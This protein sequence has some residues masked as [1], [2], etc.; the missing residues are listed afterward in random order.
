MQNRFFILDAM[1]LIYRAYFAMIRSQRITSNGVNTS[2][3]FGFINFLYDILQKEKPTHIAVCIDSMTPTF[4]HEE[5]EEYKANREKMPEEIASNLPYIREIISAFNIQL[6]ERPGFE[7]DDLIGTLATK[8]S[9]LDDFEIFIVTPDKDLSQVVNDKVK[10]FKPAHGKTPQEILDVAA[11][12]EKYN[13]SDPK[14]VIDY[15]GLVGDS[16]DNIPGV[17][18]VGPVA[19]K[20]LIGEF[21]TIENIIANVDKIKNNSLKNKIMA[22]VDNAI[23]S[24]HLATIITDV[25]CEKDIS[26]FAVQQPD[27]EAVINICE[28]LEFRL[29]EKRF[30]TDLSL[31]GNFPLHKQDPTAQV[32]DTQANS[33]NTQPASLYE[34]D[35]MLGGLFAPEEMKSLELP[36]HNNINNT[37]H[38]YRLVTSDEDIDKLI[39]LLGE[40]KTF[41]FD[42]ET[43]SLNANDCDLVGMSF[44]IE[45]H[46]AFFVLCPDNYDDTLRILKKFQPLFT[47]KDNLIIGQNI[48]FDM[49]VL[50]L[51]GIT[52]ESKIFDTMIAH[53]LINP[54]T[55]HN[56]NFLSELY[57]DYSPV[58]IETLIG[59]KG[60]N[61]GNMRNVETEPLKEY[62]A[63]DA[64]VTLQLYYKLEKEI[65]DSGYDKLFEN[66]EMPLVKVLAAMEHEGVKIDTDFLSKYRIAI[67][68]DIRNLEKQIYEYAGQQFNIG[69]PKQL[70]EILFDKL[71]LADK[72]KKTKKGQYSTNEEVL[73]KLQYSH[74]IIQ[75][76]I[77]YRS[78]TKL[79]SGYVEPLPQ[80]INHRTGMVHTT[81]N[82]AI[83]ATGRL[84]SNNPNLQN[85]PVRTE[86]GK[87]IRK[88][89]IPRDNEH[90]I[91]SA[92]YSQIELRLIAHIADDKNMQQ[93]FI[94]GQDVHKATA[95]QIFDVDIAD[96]DSEM[97]R[98]AKTINFGIIY[99]M[100]TFG[101]AER[102]HVP[103]TKASYI[104]SQYFE[105]YPAIK[106]Y[107]TDI[108]AF[109]KENG[110]V[111]TIMG[112]RR[113]IA[114]I[115]SA[116]ANVR[117]YA[118]RNAINAP[119][120]GASADMIKVAMVRINN[121][122]K[123]MG[124]QSKMIIQVHDELV[125]DAL[126]TEKDTLIDIV[127]HEM[128]NAV[129][130]AIPIEV[131]VGI[132]DNWLEAH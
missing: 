32:S 56:M 94:E 70:G 54:E 66:V 51:Y 110:Y 106:Q 73:Q 2:A 119:I 101:L 62:A 20:K 27:A 12:C 109:A 50:A 22:N 29:F 121:R 40:T 64:D 52:I 113:Y 100:S 123:E 59:K 31:S 26:S 91:I 9:Q 74:P 34:N 65:H 88:A 105:K 128:E 35:Y 86:R 90:I 6:I 131:S 39:K 82:Q 103:R 89:F 8:A 18:G 84:S 57:L 61:Q 116:N 16:S 67:S 78:L 111:E 115:N 36:K 43:T 76:I 104:I 80:L 71:H 127:V 98:M 19:A 107:M 48:K 42:T 69:S 28:K 55:Q 112:R 53:Y 4:R 21:G 24:K 85:I 102:L 7:A 33:S 1:A 93:A 81:F 83:V 44:S 30:I 60:I 92:D 38:D 77:D 15:L 23:L 130:L 17:S 97:R 10:L 45:P 114:D 129:K 132:G 37:A 79:L 72:P 41:S 117:G 68:D 99:G 124:L 11:V 75:C 125:F 126:K 46:K 87:E 118:E 108:V 49:L 3:A 95:A 25:D 58:E 63:E 122:M 96:V 120:Q 47:S 5:Y 13:V 14:Q